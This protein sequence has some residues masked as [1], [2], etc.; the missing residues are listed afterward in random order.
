MFVDARLDCL[1][2]VPE[3]PRREALAVEIGRQVEKCQGGGTEIDGGVRPH[4]PEAVAAEW[5]IGLRTA[6][7]HDRRSLVPGPVRRFLLPLVKGR[8]AFRR[9]PLFGG[10]RSFRFLSVESSGSGG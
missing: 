8:L 4:R 1:S 10:V 3:F 9:R 5:G 6:E 7:V 2:Y